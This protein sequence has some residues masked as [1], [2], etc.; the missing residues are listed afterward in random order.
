MSLIYL[1]QDINR[2]LD[3]KWNSK[4]LNQFLYGMSALQVATVSLCHKIIPIFVLFL[5]FWSLYIMRLVTV[6]DSF[7]VHIGVFLFEIT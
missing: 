4:G 6:H 3:W 5:S 2:E 1:H 7:L